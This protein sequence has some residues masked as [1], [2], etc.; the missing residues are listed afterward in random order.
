MNFLAHFYLSCDREEILVGNY[1]ADFLRNREV[2]LLP[3]GVR[4]G[5]VL[6]RKID[7]YTDNHPRIR[8]ATARLRARHG[9]YAPVVMD[10]FA[11]FLL[12]RHW[13][14]YSEVPFAAFRRNTYATIRRYLPLMSPTVARQTRLMIAD[15]FLKEYASEAGIERVFRRMRRRV[16]RPEYLLGARQS[17]EEGMHLLDEDFQAF[18][19]D[20]INFVRA[21]CS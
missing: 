17:L 2:A 21:E 5:V 16:S 1:L 3:P 9:K 7:T 13:N 19:P 12:A 6:H 4:A 8:L 11:D 20:I 18:F 10:V 14:D 15:D